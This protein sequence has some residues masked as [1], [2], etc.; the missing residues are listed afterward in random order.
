MP[1]FSHDSNGCNVG[2]LSNHLPLLASPFMKKFS[3]AWVACLWATAFSLFAD[4][5]NFVTKTLIGVDVNNPTSIDIGPD[6][7]VY[8]STQEG[9][10]YAYAVERSVEGDYSVTDTEVIDIIQTIPNH[11][12]DGALSVSVNTRQVTGIMVKGTASNPVIYVSSSDPRIGGGASRGDLS[13][14]TN[15]GTLSRLIWD[16][17]EWPSRDPIK[18]RG[19]VNL[20]GMVGNSPIERID[21][22]GENWLRAACCATCI[23]IQIWKT[24]KCA[25]GKLC[26]DKKGL[27]YYWCLI[28]QSLD[29]S[30]GAEFSDCL[31]EAVSSP[32]PLAAMSNCLSGM[33]KGAVV[34]IAQTATCACCLGSAAGAVIRSSGIFDTP[35]LPL[36]AAAAA[37]VD[38]DQEKKDPR[39]FDP[40]LPFAPD[41]DP[42]FR[43]KK[44]DPELNVDLIPQFTIDSVFK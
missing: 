42:M 40:E 19:G 14:D 8:L 37:V 28:K 5:T 27:E 9:L 23:G 20:Y 29:F 38:G 39:I 24:A 6:G 17:V 35:R 26:A 15:S 41:N 36:P 7:R 3:L 44:F 12:D 30:E 32:D 2:F 34:D 1:E 10:I 25:E 4:S 16:G 13:L 22:L 21:I 11:D 18:E 33:S 31:R 43:T